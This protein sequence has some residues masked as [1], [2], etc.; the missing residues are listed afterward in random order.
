VFVLIIRFPSTYTLSICEGC[1]YFSLYDSKNRLYY[2]RDVEGIEKIKINFPFAITL[3]TN[4]DFDILNVSNLVIKDNQIE[5]PTYERKRAK[6]F[7]ITHSNKK[8]S[9]SWINTHTG[10]I[11]YNDIFLKLSLPTRLFILLHEIGHF[12]YKTEWK[13]DLFAY[14]HFMALGHN[15]SQ[16]FYSISKVLS[17]TKKNY[18]RI[19]NLFNQ[20]KKSKQ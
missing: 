10:E 13:A 5:L 12:Y 1:K 16:A 19:E 2:K 14:K 6:E 9:P 8:T 3:K 7:T 17:P 15:S 11:F 20:I 4:N 18:I